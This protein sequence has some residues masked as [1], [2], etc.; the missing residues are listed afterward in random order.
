VLLGRYVISRRQVLGKGGFGTVFKGLD[1]ERNV[2]VAIKVYSSDDATSLRAFKNAVETLKAIKDQAQNLGNVWAHK[3]SCDNG[4]LQRRLT[5]ELNSKEAA[6]VMQQIESMDFTTC[7]VELLDFSCNETGQPDEDLLSGEAFMVLELGGESLR[8]RLSGYLADEGGPGSLPL[9][10]LRQ[11]LWSLVVIVWT[12]HTAGY[13]HLDIKPENVVAF[14][15]TL[16]KDQVNWKLIDLDGA[17][18]TGY[19][20]APDVGTFS[21]MYVSPEYARSIKEHQQITASRLM[22]VWSVAMCAMDGIFL[23]PVLEPFYRDWNQET[24]DD[25]KFFRWLSDVT[26]EPIVSGDMR[27]LIAGMDNELCSLL[28]GML[29]RNPQRRLCMAKCLSHPYFAQVRLPVIREDSETRQHEAPMKRMESRMSFRRLK[30]SQT[31]SIS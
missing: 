12:L 21:P 29:V 8:D 10:E 1:K 16:H 15:D 11:L 26:N 25:V 28:E 18:Q 6:E 30:P 13:V 7:M 2:N 5:G 22:D 23:Q 4:N 27:E 24:G 19:K 17:V 9:S 14:R 31:C 3:A 20:L